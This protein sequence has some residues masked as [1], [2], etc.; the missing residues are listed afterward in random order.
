MSN[1]DTKAVITMDEARL[2]VGNIKEQEL[3]ILNY[4]ANRYMAPADAFAFIQGQIYTRVRGLISMGHSDKRGLLG[5]ET[6]VLMTAWDNPDWRARARCVV[7]FKNGEEYAAEGHASKESV[8]A[9]IGKSRDNITHM[10]QTRATGRALRLAIGC[11]ITTIE[12]MV[13]ER[14]EPNPPRAMAERATART[15]RVTEVVTDAEVIVDAEPVEN[16]YDQIIALNARITELCAALDIAPPQSQQDLAV[17][18]K[19]YGWVLTG[20]GAAS[21][22]WKEQLIVRLEIARQRATVAAALAADPDA[23]AKLTEAK[24]TS[25]D[26]MTAEEL[27]KTLTWLQNRARRQASST[28]AAVSADTAAEGEPWTEPDVL[29]AL[30]AAAN[31]GELECIAVEIITAHGANTLTD[32]QATELSACVDLAERAFK[33]TSAGQIAQ[34]EIDAKASTMLN[35][36][37]YDAVV[38]LT[39]RVRVMH[40]WQG[41]T[42]TNSRQP[43]TA[44]AR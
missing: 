6:E 22:T 11:D 21:L 42:G 15:P 40:S 39:R 5:I 25:L 20:T 4:Y 38:A 41:S 12:E 19:T 26:A 10:A 7:R 29:N 16:E 17:L 32:S 44:G 24:V 33:A 2:L 9:N 23:A 28:E 31:A 36:D 14:A 37:Q 30:A 43:A 27:D 8:N 13:D 1:T 3:A 34:V 35:V 18:G